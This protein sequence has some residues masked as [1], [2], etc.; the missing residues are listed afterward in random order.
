MTPSGAHVERGVFGGDMR[1]ESVNDGPITLI[2][3]A[4]SSGTRGLAP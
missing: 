2:L 3:E 4:Q 1:V